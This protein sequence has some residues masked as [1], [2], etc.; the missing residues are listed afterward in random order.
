MAEFNED[1]LRR[2]VRQTI[3]DI[4]AR[5]KS[6]VKPEQ[7]TEG[8]SL[9]VRLGIDSLDILQLMATLE[10]KFKLRIPEEELREMDNLGGIIKVVKRHW[11]AGA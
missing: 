7:I 1:M 3:A 4:L 9:T 2:E 10:K 11:P 5:K 6:A 8:M